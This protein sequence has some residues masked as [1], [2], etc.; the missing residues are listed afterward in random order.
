MPHDRQRSGDQC[1]LWVQVHFGDGSEPSSC[2]VEL[3]SNYLN[4]FTSPRNG[5]VGTLD[6]RFRLAGA[7]LPVTDPKRRKR[8]NDN[9]KVDHHPGR[10]VGNAIRD[11]VYSKHKGEDSKAEHPQIP[12]GARQERVDP[13]GSSHISCRTPASRRRRR[14][15][16]RRTEQKRAKPPN[17]PKL[18]SQRAPTFLR[19]GSQT[20][21]DR[22][23]QS[24]SARID[25]PKP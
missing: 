9:V 14:A 24:A 10:M 15:G 2:S 25:M 3:F 17:E 5:G 20:R 8:R 11:K 19:A 18:G 21:S 23:S 6:S 1:F 16:E 13:L 4:R 22:S 12:Y 7:E